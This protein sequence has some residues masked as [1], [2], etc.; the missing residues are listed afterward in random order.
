MLLRKYNVRPNILIGI[1]QLSLVFGILFNRLLPKLWTTDF[2]E[3][4]SAG[5]GGML[6]GVS[7]VLNGFAL[8][9]Y[10]EMKKQETPLG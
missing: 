8:R 1:A 2:G 9:K 7:L 10:R 3:G 5:L 6:I 4:F